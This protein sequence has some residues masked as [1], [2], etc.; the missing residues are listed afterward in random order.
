LKLNLFRN[1]EETVS[2]A[3]LNKMY[4]K[5]ARDRCIFVQKCCL[6]A[7]NL[8]FIQTKPEFS[9]GWGVYIINPILSR[10]V[11]KG[12]EPPLGFLPRQK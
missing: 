1:F 10:G 8:I 6:N 2:V 5:K 11:V 4:K 12:A 3:N 7:G 9:G